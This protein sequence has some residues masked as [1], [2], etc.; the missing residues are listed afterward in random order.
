[1]PYLMQTNKGE[2]LN[3]LY[4]EDRSIKLVSF[5]FV[6]SATSRQGLYCAF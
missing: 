4:P 3:R 1:M 2:E 6:I 5:C